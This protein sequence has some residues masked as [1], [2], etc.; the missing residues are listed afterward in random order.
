MKSST[1]N[2]ASGNIKKAL[3]VFGISALSLLPLKSQA[4]DNKGAEFGTWTHPIGVV[5]DVNGTVM[6]LNQYA[7]NFL[8]LSPDKQLNAVIESDKYV[9]LLLALKNPNALPNFLK[10]NNRWFDLAWKTN[11]TPA[12]L[13]PKKYNTGTDIANAGT[14][15]ANYT[16]QEFIQALKNVKPGEKLYIPDNFDWGTS[17]VDIY[18]KEI[19]PKYAPEKLKKLPN[20]KL[21]ADAKNR[22]YSVSYDPE[23]NKKDSDA[24][25][26]FIENNAKVLN[27]TA[28]T[29]QVLIKKGAFNPNLSVADQKKVFAG[30]VSKSFDA[31]QMF[32]KEKSGR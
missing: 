8:K 21:A 19:L 16:L 9:I 20:A 6:D 27:A 12:M 24:L 15:L 29:I 25:N 3:T 22:L 23:K 1:F 13:S 30:L 26:L 2:A 4:Q 18:R 31:T 14:E 17:V 10:L 28:E 11:K 32:I 7:A 5:N